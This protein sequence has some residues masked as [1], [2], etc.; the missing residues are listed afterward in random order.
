VPHFVVTA[1]SGAV[2]ISLVPLVAL[3]ISAVGGGAGISKIIEGVLKI[4]AGMSA[5]ESKRK[6]DIVQQRD[7]ALARESKAWHVVDGEARKRRAAQDE[8]ARLRRLCIVHGIDPGDEPTF[9][10]TITRAELTELRQQ[11]EK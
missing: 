8:V 7:D 4:R 1:S 9:T 2:Q 5:R 3:L 6:I 11:E 10:K